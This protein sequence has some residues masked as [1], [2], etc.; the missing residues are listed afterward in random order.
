MKQM[1]GYNSIL[2]VPATLRENNQRP[3][4]KSAWENETVSGTI[5]DLIYL[6]PRLA[7]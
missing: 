7:M 5:L 2:Y 6:P 4:A 1:N 3:S